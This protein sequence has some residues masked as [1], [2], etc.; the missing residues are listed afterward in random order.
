M[1]NIS[2][3]TLAAFFVTLFILI[4]A[5]STWPIDQGRVTLQ[6]DPSI[7][8]NVAGYR[9]HFGAITGFYT[10]HTDVGL[11]TSY[12]VDGLR[13]LTT[14]Y[15]AVT[16]YNSAQ[17][18][19]IFSNEVS[20]AVPAAPIVT[21]ISA[22]SGIAGMEIAVEGDNLT[23]GTA[24]QFN[25]VPASIVSMSSTTIV[26]TVPSGAGSGPLTVTTAGGTVFAAN[27]TIFIPVS[28]T[29]L[30]VPNAGAAIY[31]TIG[32]DNSLRTG[33]AL[34]TAESDSIPYGTAVFSY[35]ENG[36][37]VSEVGVP[38]VSATRAVRFFV[39]HRPNVLAEDGGTI[40]IY[41]GFAT[42]NLNAATANL[43]LILRD[44]E[45]VI[46]TQ[47]TIQL[48]PGCQL[49]RYIHQLAPDFIL[50]VNF[51]SSGFGSLEITSD[52][53]VSIIALRLT[54]NQRGELLITCTPMADL[55][56]RRHRNP[57]IF[58][59]WQLEVASRPH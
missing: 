18:E 2:Y 15:F 48:D 37:V 49:A 40:G 7:S 24:V 59:S 51:A 45:G 46:L 16:A 53:P 36:A 58:R 11:K 5:P 41:T 26:A 50:P 23:P 42:V 33:Y 38:A 6:W 19:S 27:F 30:L 31:D 47:G 1:S 56:H 52:Q 3:R 14:Y 32:P 22:T 4:C 25:G 29:N 13:N 44:S 20:F 55:R 21:K 57:C 34:A 54:I 12:R 35:R 10:S 43:H 28:Q 39:D 9:V 8:S 17:K